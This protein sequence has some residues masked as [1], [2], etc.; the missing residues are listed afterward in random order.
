MAGR[1]NFA[2]EADDAY[3]RAVDSVLAQLDVDPTRGLAQAEVDRRIARHGP[4][5]L[6]ASEGVRWPALFARQFADVLI[7]I[8]ALAAVLSLLIG[9]TLD[10]A[11]IAAI[12]IFNA[13]LGFAQEWK[14]ARA[15]A[16]LKRMVSPGCNALRDGRAQAVAAASLVPGD[17][18]LLRTGDRVP[19]DL[20]LL[21]SRELRI[22]ES[23]LTGESNPVAKQTTAV[24]ENAPLAER[25]SAA[26]M[27]TAICHG[28]GIGVVTATGMHTEIG[29]IARITQA[30]PDERTPLQQK[31]NR[32]GRQLGFVAV[33][34]STFVAVAGWWL[35]KP[36]IEM[37]MTGVSLAV[38]VVPEGL[39][40]VVT[41]TL[42]LGIRAMIRRRALLR[43]L[44]AAETLGSATVICTDKTGTLTR[45]EMTLREV[46]LRSG[47]WSATGTGY[48]PEGAFELH[49]PATDDRR[50]VDLD[51]L[52]ITGLV[53]NHAELAREDDHW[54]AIGEPTEAALLTAARKARADKP[55]GCEPIREFSFSSARK[56]M[57]VLV[58]GT[59]ETIA[60]VKGA[61]EI[62]LE[63]CT[64]V[65]DAG[66]ERELTAADRSLAIEAYQR[67]A[68]QGLRTLAL[69]RRSLAT[70]S[71][72]DPDVVERDLSLLGVVGILD[73]PRP[74]VAEAIRIARDAGIRVLMITGDAAA[75][76]LTIA[77]RVG[78][79]A[80]SAISGPELDALDDAA[81]R[82][83]LD[84]EVVV[85]R[86]T[87]E[88]KLRIVSLLQ[89]MG[90][91]VAMTGDGVNDAPALKKADVGIAMGIRGTEVA[92]GASDMVL[93][94]DNFASIVGA[95][96]E[97]RRQY[98]N[99]QKFVRYLLSSN[100]GEVTAILVNVLLGG[101]LI[102]LPV[103]ILWMNLV[104]DGVT[105]VALGLEPV[106]PGVME[107]AARDQ[108]RPILDRPGILAILGLGGYIG[109]A[110]LLLF[111][112]YLDVGDPDALARAQTLAF[113]GIIVME[114]V[115]I[116]NF[117]A[118]RAPL[119]AVGWWS[120][121]WITL[122][123]LSMLG[124]QL[125]AVYVPF[126]QRA[127]HT[128]SLDGF[129]WLVMLVVALPLLLV[130][131]TVKRWRW[132]HR[133]SIRAAAN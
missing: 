48:D 18:V 79:R 56:R 80:Q 106:E 24:T 101:P 32:L 17:I 14:A 127:L 5:A 125:A 11:A 26:W 118:L 89:Q 45:N 46:W 132:R 34:I 119:S 129:D 47:S 93:T 27:G 16:A 8:L 35:G 20:R 2:L 96:E 4:N 13:V 110:T 73:P 78:L 131:E 87:P 105:S 94:D 58:R 115:N 124:L 9:D 126:M 39:P 120:N 69:A 100:T 41:I 31:L 52:L 68:R 33:A 10:A 95:V 85:A 98:D 55:V 83:A 54:I 88:H 53:C 74:E 72:D 128:V 30:V 29:R 77:D 111:Q 91:V 104:T 65:F 113:T 63:R 38:A 50:A 51:A 1:S 42:A 99:I 19:A 37:F 75:T 70:E 60:H 92:K 66:V 15:I 108:R 6:A 103:Q 112:Y 28:S 59:G 64:R 71:A 22:D 43:S 116:F 121:R 114:K 122:A 49:S 97:G 7:A 23:S 81:L 117:R 107:R 90:H 84:R 133:T 21:E 57:T 40:A 25:H 67:F 76:A 86:V 62:I 130:G 109:I 44:S 3:A 102:L 123:V 82:T 36:A 61:P 12:L